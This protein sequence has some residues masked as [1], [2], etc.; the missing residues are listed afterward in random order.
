MPIRHIIGWRFSI[1]DRYQSHDTNAMLH[2]AAD[3]SSSKKQFSAAKRRQQLSSQSVALSSDFA[4]L[5]NRR[6]SHPSKQGKE[7]KRHEKPPTS[8]ATEKIGNK[9]AKRMGMSGGAATLLQ[10]EMKGDLNV[11]QMDVSQ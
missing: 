6:Q 7:S 3:S 11:E 1:F 8:S 5:E 9:A 10:T 4:V 2:G